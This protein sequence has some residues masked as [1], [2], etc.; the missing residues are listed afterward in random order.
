M[1]YLDIKKTICCDDVIQSLFDLNGLDIIVYK[2][3]R[4]EGETRADDLANKLNRE[5]STIY[6]SLQKLNSCGLCKKITRTITKGGY[7]HTYQCDDYDNIKKRLDDCIERWYKKM[8][9]TV[10]DLD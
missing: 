10:Q 2:E 6:R 1:R 5:R 3:L 9:K 8:K 7:Y 4:G